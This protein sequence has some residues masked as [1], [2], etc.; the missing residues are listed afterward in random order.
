M[1]RDGKE[2]ALFGRLQY[3]S[4]SSLTAYESG[5]VAKLKLTLHPSHTGG[6]KPRVVLGR[7]RHFLVELATVPAGKTSHNCAR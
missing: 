4:R 7:I 6:V 5:D 2:Y 3:G 1:V